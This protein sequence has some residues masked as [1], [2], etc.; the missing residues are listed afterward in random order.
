MYALVAELWASGPTCG[1]IGRLHTFA[2]L[3]LLSVIVSSWDDTG[4]TT[5]G[6]LSMKV[7]THTN[8][9]LSSRGASVPNLWALCAKPLTC[10]VR[11]YTQIFYPC[12][13]LYRVPV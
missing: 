5:I 6:Q 7:C 10:K 2:K 3:G 1:P 12:M 8:L 9:S 11:S 13:Y 4:Q